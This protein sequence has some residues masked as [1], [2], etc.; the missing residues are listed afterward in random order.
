MRSCL[1]M[2]LA[3]LSLFAKRIDVVIPVHK[4]DARNLDVIINGLE[5]RVEN[6]GRVIVISK[7]RFTDRAEW[8]SE[9]EFPFTIEDVADEIGGEGGIGRNIRRGWY[10]Q[11]LLKFY[12]HFVI[13]DLSEDIL[14]LD[15]DTI[16]TKPISFF[17]EEG[18]VFMDYRRINYP[19]AYKRHT[20]LMLCDKADVRRREN[21]VVHHMVF[22]RAILDDLFAMVEERYGKPFWQ[23]FANLVL[24]PHK[25]TK[26]GFYMGA[27]E[28]MIY[29]FYATTC[30]PE[31][32]VMRHIVLDDHAGSLA[33]GGSRRADFKSCHNYDRRE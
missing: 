9:E 26:N 16:P 19:S 27:S 23:V 10:Y 6:L 20:L 1:I 18:R 12:A 32:V 3:V 11:Q 31:K 30:H 7:R 8:V 13:D 14:I 21:P 29:Y 2:V 28:Y 17:D 33:S 25:C 4:K 5:E 15:S 24:P 22:S